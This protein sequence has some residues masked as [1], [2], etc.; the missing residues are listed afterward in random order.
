MKLEKA[1]AS[2]IGKVLDLLNWEKLFRNKNLDTQVSIF[3]ETILN[4]FSNF[5]PNKT[6]TCNDEDP[7]RMNEKKSKSKNQLCKVLLN[8]TS[9]SQPLKH[10]TIKILRRG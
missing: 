5:I 7:I 4:I 9:L 6:I 2:G 10:P 3:N 8:L 1:I